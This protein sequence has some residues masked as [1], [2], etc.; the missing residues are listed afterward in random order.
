MGA[1]ILPTA[2]YKGQLYFLFGLENE[3]A[4]TKG[5]AD[6]GGGRDGNET[7]METAIREF[8][9]ETTGFWGSEEDI[10]KQIDNVGSAFLDHQGSKHKNDFYRTYIVPFPYDETFVTFYNNNHAFIKKRLPEAV[11]RESKI[12][13][14]SHVVWMSVNELA[15]KKRQ[16]R[17][18]YRPIVKLLIDN[19]PKI[20]QF[21]SNRMENMGGQLKTA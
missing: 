19:A 17:E 6:F 12:F 13:E 8:T 21:V 18:Y 10:K 9:E 20:H 16:F 2:I 7:W 1:G 5:Y 15:R 14:K 3:H 11:Y 4:D